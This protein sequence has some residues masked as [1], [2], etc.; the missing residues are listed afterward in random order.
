MTNDTLEGIRNGIQ[1]DT[2]REKLPGVMSLFGNKPWIYAV[3]Y[4]SKRCK[5]EKFMKKL[6][7]LFILVIVS[8]GGVLFILNFSLPAAE[9]KV[10]ADAD[11]KYDELSTNHFFDGSFE[12]IDP[13]EFLHSLEKSKGVI[14]TIG[15]ASEGW[16]KPEHIDELI[17]LVDSK[18][19]CAAV[20]S[21]LSSY[22]P[23]EGSTVGNEAM[24]LIEGYKSGKYPPALYSAG[25]TGSRDPEEYKKWWKETRDA[26]K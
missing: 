21:A 16:I 18:K 20:V 3:K 4:Y 14:T 12:K 24:F 10:K 25:G 8:G 1:M 23:P 6:L 2:G 7:I 26:E 5:M 17:K 15:F 19:P 13:L 9:T 22:L 11:I